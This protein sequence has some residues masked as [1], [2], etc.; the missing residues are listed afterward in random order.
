MLSTAATSRIAVVAAAL[1]LATACTTADRQAQDVKA[2]AYDS[3]TRDDAEFNRQ[4][5]HETADVDGVRMHY[6]TGGTGEPL[7]LLHG[8]PQSWYEWRGVMPELA[9]KHTVYALD[10]PGL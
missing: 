8:W 7:V 1:V 5:R 4:F 2:S 6:V 10:L 9:K 3:A